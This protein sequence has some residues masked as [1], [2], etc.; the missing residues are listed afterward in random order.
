MQS[1]TVAFI[2]RAVA[3]QKQADQVYEW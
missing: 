3:E 1:R 2:T